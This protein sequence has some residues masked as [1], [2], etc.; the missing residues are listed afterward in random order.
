MCLTIILKVLFIKY[1][2]ESLYMEKE[3]LCFRMKI[4]MVPLT[5]ITFACR[6]FPVE[7]YK[8]DRL[9]LVL[10]FWALA[11]TV[12]RVQVSQTDYDVEGKVFGSVLNHVT[13]GRHAQG[14]FFLSFPPQAS[15]EGKAISK[16]GCREKH[17]QSSLR[18]QVRSRT[19]V[20]S[21]LLY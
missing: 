17:S 14:Q 13:G 18:K 8:N 15:Q 2:F 7:Q 9:G 20:I 4:K 16:N 10:A 11:L 6:G 12:G 21:H 1:L 3:H 19:P 5:E